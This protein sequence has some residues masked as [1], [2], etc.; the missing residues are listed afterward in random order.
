MS[1]V[2]SV[3]PRFL[4][5]PRAPKVIAK[6]DAADFLNTSDLLSYEQFGYRLGEVISQCV[7]GRPFAT[8]QTSRIHKAKHLGD[9]NRRASDLLKFL[10]PQ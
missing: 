6:I 4:H 2:I 5:V 7:R 1:S 9:M 10:S 3:P 8:E